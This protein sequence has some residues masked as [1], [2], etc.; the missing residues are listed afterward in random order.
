[1][2]VDERRRHRLFQRLE[3]VLGPEEAA[4]LMEHLPPVGWAD[5]ATKHDLAQLE[6][7]V[8]LRFAAMQVKLDATKHELIAGFRGELVQQ[9][10]TMMRTVVLANSASVVTVAGLAFA[11]ARL[12]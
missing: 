9:T 12:T 11:A 8:D 4:A 3:E 5:V 2:A 6:S 1:M 7:R 10:R